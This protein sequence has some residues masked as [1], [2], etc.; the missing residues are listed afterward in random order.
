VAPEVMPHRLVLS[1]EALADG[2]KPNDVINTIISNVFAPALH[3][4]Q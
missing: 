2:V 1:Y 4:T 3:F